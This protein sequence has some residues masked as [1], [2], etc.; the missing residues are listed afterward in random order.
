LHFRFYPLR[1]SLVARESVYFPPGKSGNLLRGAFGAIFR[2][3]A[4]RPE[5][6]GAR[7]C[8]TAAT[9]PYARMFEPTALGSGPSGFAD[10]P[11]PFVFRATHL[12]SSRIPPGGAFTFDLNLFDLKDPAIAYL[13]LAFSQ[14]AHEG[15]GPGRGRAQLTEVWCPGQRLYDGQSLLQGDVAPTEFEPRSAA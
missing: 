15:L 8:E 5:C 13:V 2:R 7:Y 11:R 12:D 9:C 14:F 10:W 6:A 1:F 3:I 4:C